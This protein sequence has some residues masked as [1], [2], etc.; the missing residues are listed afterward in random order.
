[1]LLADAR[2][3]VLSAG[4][5]RFQ[6]GAENR[7]AELSAQ[8]LGGGYEPGV[9]TE[10]VINDADGGERVLRIPAVRDRVVERS[11]LGVLGPVID[12]LLGP[13]SFAYRPGLGVGDA[14]REVARLCEEGFAWVLRTDVHDCF[15]SIPLERLSRSLSALIADAE[16]VAV[17]RL[18]L[19]RGARRPGQRDLLAPKGWAQG[20]PLSPVLANW[21]LEPIDERVRRAGFPVVRYGDDFCVVTRSRDEAWEAAGVV[22]AAVEEAG[23]TLGADKTEVMSFADGFT[24]LGE[25]FGSRYSPVLERG[26]A[27]PQHRTVFLGVQGAGCG[28][29]TG[30]SSSPRMRSVCLTCRS[31]WW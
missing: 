27:A 25:D 4:V 10:V 8:L 30:G 6:D 5:R 19:A 15:P 3:E 2:D 18:L 16:L 31:G 11:I 20:S 21:V 7:L 29:R 23:M 12:V 26:T 17:V 13:G 22:H 28:S 14:V 9:L 24:F 1:M